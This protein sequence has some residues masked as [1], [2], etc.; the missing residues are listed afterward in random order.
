MNMTKS[1]GKAKNEYVSGRIRMMEKARLSTAQASVYTKR[2]WTSPSPRWI[3]LMKRLRIPSTIAADI[4]SP[5][6]RQVDAIL[7]PVPML[8]FEQ[9]LWTLHLSTFVL[10]VT[11]LEIAEC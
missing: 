5:I 10:F 3:R 8:D 1:N 7:A 4:N 2:F 11:M 9:C 6:R